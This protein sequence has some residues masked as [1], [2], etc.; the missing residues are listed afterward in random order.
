MT[1]TTPTPR[2]RARGRALAEAATQ[3]AE[4]VGRLTD[5]KKALD[6]AL[7]DDPEGAETLERAGRVLRDL[8]ALSAWARD[9]AGQDQRAVMERRESLRLLISA[10]TRRMFA[11]FPEV[12]RQKAVI[13]ARADRA[14]RRETELLQAGVTRD[15]LPHVM[16]LY[17]PAE[18]LTKLAALEAERDALGR[19]VAD[20]PVYD[21]R[22]LAGTIFE[23][24]EDFGPADF[25]AMFP[26]AR[27]A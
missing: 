13:K 7:S 3:L 14:S 22:L 21:I 16:G 4:A 18:D 8:Q 11:L 25:E 26:V 5:G 23:D 6:I 17:D 19:F 9:A 27:A 12:D 2:E 1:E 24:R 10:A 20:S 15:Q